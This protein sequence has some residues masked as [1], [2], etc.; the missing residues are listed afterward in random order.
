MDEQA[1]SVKANTVYK[2]GI[3]YGWNGNEYE[4][5]KTPILNTGVANTGCVAQEYGD[6]YSHQTILTISQLAALTSADNASLADG[7]LLYT[8]PAGEI[9]INSASMQIAL[10]NAEHALETPVVGL[11]TTLGS[12]AVADLT[13]PATLQNIITGTAVAGMAEE[14]LVK[15]AIPTAAVPFV[16]AD[17]DAHTLYLNMAAAWGNTAGTALDVDLSGSVIINWSYLNNPA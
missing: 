15:T 12:T 7:Y 1:G 3:F 5:I 16:I 2:N 4:E 6:S 17:G 10:T 9:I 8:F 13:N 11:G 14:V